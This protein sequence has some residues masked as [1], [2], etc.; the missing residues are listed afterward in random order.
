MKK[1][2][3]TVIGLV[4]YVLDSDTC[5]PETLIRDKSTYQNDLIAT[6]TVEPLITDLGF[7]GACFIRSLPGSKNQLV[8]H[9]SHMSP[10]TRLSW[11]PNFLCRP[12]SNQ[13][14]L[15]RLS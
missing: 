15:P 14:C 11:P 5:D 12:T 2:A 13:H 4:Y 9:S 1:L 8:F 6:P 7:S 10:F 3:V